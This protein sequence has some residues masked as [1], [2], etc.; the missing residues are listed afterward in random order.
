MNPSITR[1]IIEDQ[2]NCMGI[3]VVLFDGIDTALLGFSESGSGEWIAVYDEDACVSALEQQGMSHD[4]AIEYF[5][6]NIRNCFVGP[7]TQQFI[8]PLH[9]PGQKGPQT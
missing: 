8:T 5:E 6:F 4:D 2:L 1:E 7:Q 3:G 9:I